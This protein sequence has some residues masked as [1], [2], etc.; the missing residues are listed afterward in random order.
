MESCEGGFVV[1]RI[2]ITVFVKFYFNI[3]RTVH[4]SGGGDSYI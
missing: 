2:P 4:Y 1:E 3:N